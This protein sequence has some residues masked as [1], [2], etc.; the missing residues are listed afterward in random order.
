[1]DESKKENPGS[2]HIGGD[3]LGRNIVIGNNSPLTITEGSNEPEASELPYLIERLI[4]ELEKNPPEN[5][6][7]VEA[8]KNLAKSLETATKSNSSK[9]ILK[10][11]A[12]GLKRAAEALHGV[13]PTVLNIASQI[14]AQI[15]RLGG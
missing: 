7:D 10:V 13:T 6:Q 5:L 9:P 11:Q 4:E 3:V 2:I 14:V 12:E 1:M 8:I 15:M